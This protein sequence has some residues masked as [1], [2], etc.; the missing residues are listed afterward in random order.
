[1]GRSGGRNQDR[2]PDPDNRGRWNLRRNRTTLS[3]TAGNRKRLIGFLGLT[4]L[5][6]ATFLGL[7]AHEYWESY[8][9]LNMTLHSGIYGATFYILTGF[10]GLHVTL[11]TIMLCVMWLRCVRGHF[12]RDHHFAFEAVSWY[13]HF[14][15]VIW[16]CLFLFVYIL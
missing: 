14:V 6:G 13:W 10:H 1:M 2:R 8:V 3:G 5:L 15:D 9:H 7:Q 11:G 12:S 4:I 16:L